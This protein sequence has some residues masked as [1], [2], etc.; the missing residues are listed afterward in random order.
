[1]QFTCVDYYNTG[2][3]SDTS[4][5][6]LW[7]HWFPIQLL[8][9]KVLQHSNESDDSEIEKIVEGREEKKLYNFPGK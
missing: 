7:Y 3:N 6:S 2:T 1:M 5:L 4:L 8:K 9:E